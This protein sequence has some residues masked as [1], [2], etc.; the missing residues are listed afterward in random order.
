MCFL[1][2][3]CDEPNYNS[4][5][6]ALCAMRNV[7]LIKV[8]DNKQ[9]GIWAGLCKLDKK[10]EA[11][12]IVRTSAVVITNFGEASPYLEWLEKEYKADA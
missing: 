4:L 2:K 12:K 5:V 7:K 9:L 6:E 11:R 10:A 3:N 8:P 1:A